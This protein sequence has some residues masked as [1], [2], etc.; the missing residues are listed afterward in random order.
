MK[1]RPFWYIRR[2]SVQSDI[3]EELDLHLEMKIEELRARGMPIEDARQEALRQF[4][5]LERTREYCRRQDE[6]KETDMQRSLML[7]DFAQDIRIGIR[8]LVRVPVLTVTIIVTVG[9]GIGATAAIF[10]AIDA[11]LLQ[12]LPYAHSDRLVRIFTDAPPFK[13]RFSVA[14]YLA[15]REQQ[16]QFE[17]SAT[18]TDRSVIWSDGVSSEVVRARVVSWT[19]FSVLGIQPAIGRDFAEPDGRPGTPPSII[20]SHAFWQQGLGS[21]ADAIGRPIKLDGA[22]HTVVGVLPPLS[23]PLERR[24][25]LFLIQQFSAPARKGPF[26]YSVVARLRE[27]TDWSVAA[28]ELRAINKRIFPVWRTS[29]QDDKATWSME[30]LKTAIVGDVNAIAGL[31]LASVAFVWLIACANASNLLI[32]R[33][34]SRRQELAVRAALG[35]SRGRVVRYLLAE[36]V[37]LGTGAVAVGACVAWGGVELL[38]GIGSTYF[39]RTQEMALDAPELWLLGGLTA[40]SGLIFGLVPAMHGTGGSVDASLRSLGRS[41]T[42]SLTVRRLRRALVA[43]QFAIAT[44]LLIVAGLLL[45]SLNQLKNVDLGFDHRNL[46]TGSVRLPA[47]QYQ[48][49]GRVRVF[50][51]ELTRRMAA[52]PGVTGVAFAD[53]LPPSGVGNLNN[54]D[55]EDF[56]APPGQSQPST[57]WVATTPEYFRVLGLTLLEGR[58]LDERDALTQDLE[59]V[60]VDRAW[61]QRFFPNRSAV[62]KRFREGGCTTCPWISVVGVVSDVKYLGLDEPD[63]GTVYSPISEQELARFLVVRTRADPSTLLPALQRVVRELDP[64][65]PLSNIATMDDLVTQSLER[66][67]SLSWLVATFALVALVLSVVGISGVMGYYVHQ[68]LKDISIRMALGGSS[69]DVLRLVMGHGMRVVVTG[70]FLGVLAA[71]G[72]TRL[73]SSLLFG[74]TAAD[75]LTFL[76][77]SGGLVIVALVACFV[78][79]RRAIGIQ[80]AT[81]LRNE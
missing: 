18:Y 42:G 53:G 61:A 73:M 11:A 35:A 10:S 79:A 15:F 50:W 66:P 38:Q 12:P 4:G 17:E 70:V 28:S 33:V 31:A 51:D 21:R 30:D 32:A 37:L 81:V 25:D 74:V 57:P 5:D 49:P 76:T 16:T 14:D 43:A 1:Q 34:T 54:F 19:F 48:E 62:G 78:P 59:S 45:S 71:L 22:E 68:H 9:V 67:Q 29:Y 13:W 60:V 72:V 46:I 24:Q 77:V 27:G 39:P 65:A 47:G 80:P 20:A 7:Q 40:C 58:L 2:T 23:G 69:A 63:D 56:P 44:P 36:S 55:L 52:V 26:L 8:S 41:S 6:E 3:D 64:S 75:A